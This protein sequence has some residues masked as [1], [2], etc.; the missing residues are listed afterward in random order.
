MMRVVTFALCTAAAALGASSAGAAPLEARNPFHCSVAIQVSYE[1]A[2]SGRGA[3]DP[4]TRELH[5]RL[6]YQAFAAARFPKALDSAEEAGVMSKQLAEDPDAAFALTEACIR[7]QDASPKFREAR[8]QKQVAD[9]LPQ[10]EVTAHA[11]LAELK[12][13]FQAQ[14]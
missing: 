8:L 7:R 5:S 14:R 13:L 3:E 11:S 12:G 6:V 4:L 2:K 9:G 10:A 1:L